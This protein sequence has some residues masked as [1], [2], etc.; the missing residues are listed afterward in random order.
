MQNDII[1]VIHMHIQNSTV[2]FIDDN[3]LLYFC[4]YVQTTPLEKH[5]YIRCLKVMR[6]CFMSLLS[7]LTPLRM[8]SR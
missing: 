4:V 2:D 3:W 5:P 6:S 8:S 7:C 1:I